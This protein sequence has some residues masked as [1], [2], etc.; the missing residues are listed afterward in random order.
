MRVFISGDTLLKKWRN[1]RDRWMKH[2][3]QDKDSKKSGAGS[4]KIKK[5]VYHEQL[6]FLKKVSNQ[7]DTESSINV[8]EGNNPLSPT[9]EIIDDPGTPIPAQ[10]NKPKATRK[11]RR[12]EDEFELKM[13]KVLEK[14][15]DDEETF[16]GFFRSMVPT[17]KTF[18]S[19]QFVE[20]QLGVLGVLKNVKAQ[21][22]CQVQH[23]TQYQQ[24]HV[25]YPMN[26]PPNLYCPQPQFP[27]L[28]SNQTYMN[29]LIR[30]IHPHTSTSNQQPTPPPRIPTPNRSTDTP[31]S[32]S[33]VS[34]DFEGDS[35]DW[36][37][38]STKKYQF[39]T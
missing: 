5:Y 26:Q 8:P 2:I 9:D 20:F 27:Q 10:P 24:S 13:M 29:P 16:F 7:H 32:S 15:Y 19:D 36:S 34:L 23:N 14:P 11:R 37:I 38:E 31:A 21:G 18:T 22:T 30:P 33:I 3:R 6:Q 12:N 25:P 35:N 28:F 4:S 1:V 39:L 17:L